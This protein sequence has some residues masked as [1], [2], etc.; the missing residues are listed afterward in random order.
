MSENNAPAT[1]K[2]YVGNLSYDT[3][4]ASL[5]AHFTN[6]VEGAEIQKVNI[7]IDRETNRPKGF[8]FVE[9][10]TVDQATEVCDK[11][12]GK[13]LDGRAIKVM[14]AQEQ[15]KRDGGSRPRSG[16][17]DRGGFGRPSRRQCRQY[18]R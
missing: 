14:K 18:Q 6:N 17:G 15:V 10:A 7:I 3:D 12:N 16:G 4:E 5:R 2:V 1:N 13:E 11:L 9:M 8:A